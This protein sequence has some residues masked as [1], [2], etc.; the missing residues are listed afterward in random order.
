MNKIY[1]ELF[2]GEC[3]MISFEEGGGL[4]LDFCFSRKIDGYVC[5]AHMA[6]RIEGRERELNLGIL[7]D[8]EYSPVLVIGDERIDLPRIRKHAG[9][10]FPV[11][12]DIAYIDELSLRTKRIADRLKGIEDKLENMEK[13]IKGSRIF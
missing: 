13:L 5:L 2:D 8:G 12:H 7:P 3:E 9:A 4:L 11:G 10:L 6:A 1:I